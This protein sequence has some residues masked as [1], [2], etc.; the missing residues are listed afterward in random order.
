[1]GDLKM[2]AAYIIGGGMIFFVG[3]A[4]G[5]GSIVGYKG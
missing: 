5:R 4:V 1:M 2:Y 3:E